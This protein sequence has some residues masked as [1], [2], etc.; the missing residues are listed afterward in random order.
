MSDEPTT[1][2][3]TTPAAQQR[4][5]R[6][7]LLV[8][9]LASGANLVDAARTVGVAERT[10]R[11]WVADPDFRDRIRDARHEAIGSAYGRLVSS[12]TSAA[13]ALRDLLFSDHAGIKLRAAQVI[14]A[15]TLRLRAALELEQRVHDLE[16]RLVESK[17]P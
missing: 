8:V 13:D 17:N 15:E 5:Q 14:L 2:E 3:Q 9:A 10:V 4:Q 12:L 16:Q 1:P 11:R 6:R 7:E